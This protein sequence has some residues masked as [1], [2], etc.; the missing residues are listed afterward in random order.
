MYYPLSIKSVAECCD[1]RPF[2]KWKGVV[3]LP[4]SDLQSV[5]AMKF[6]FDCPFKIKKLCLT[7]HG[8]GIFFYKSELDMLL[9]LFVKFIT[10]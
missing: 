1:M 8:R 2:P 7:V 6:M 9:I 5:N 4:R 10:R 3:W